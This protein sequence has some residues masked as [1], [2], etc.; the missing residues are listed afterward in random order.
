MVRVKRKLTLI[1]I[2]F[3]CV[4]IICGG[5]LVKYYLEK[6][7]TEKEMEDLRESLVLPDRNAEGEDGAPKAETWE[8]DGILTRYHSLYEQNNDMAG[9]IQI[10][11]TVIDY[12]VLYNG[13][14]NAFYLHR[15]FN[16][17]N[18]DA[19]IPFLDYQCDRAGNSDNMIVYGHN[20][21]NGTMFHDL[22]KYADQEFYNEH[23][24]V[25]FDTVYN[26]CVYEVFAAFRVRVGSKDEFRYYDFINSDT[27][28]AY[29]AYV[30]SCK[31]HSLYDTGITPSYREKLLTLSTCS[32]NSGNERFV[33]VARLTEKI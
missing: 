25:R 26:R 2:L 3:L 18:S 5:I 12:P 8:A 6:N 31:A 23:K 11:G 4:F 32:Y 10:D 22:L 13:E 19:G 15:N 9:W 16:K 14:S 17:E 30:S 1:Q 24:Y 7:N 27:T 33:I 21:R 28:E 20:M 29:D